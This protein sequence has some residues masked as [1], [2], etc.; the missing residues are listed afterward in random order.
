MGLFHISIG[1]G[2]VNQWIYSISRD[3]RGNQGVYSRPRDRR[4]GCDIESKF[5]LNELK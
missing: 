1:I 5:G 4:G 2:E 3:R